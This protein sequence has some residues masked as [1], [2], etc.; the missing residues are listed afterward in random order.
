MK[1]LFT[2]LLNLLYP[3]LCIICNEILVRGES[4]ICLKCLH[5]M[6]K[7]NYHL[8]TDNTVEKRFWGKVQVHRATSCFHFYKGS[9][10]QKLL[11]ELKYHGNKEVGRV[12][13]KYAAIDLLDSPDF[14]SVDVIVPVPLHPKKYAKRGYNQSEWIAKG[15]SEVLNKP[16]DNSHLIRIRENATQTKKSIF[17]RY[18]NT[19]GIFTLNDETVFRKKHVLLVDDVLTTGSTLEACMMALMETDYITISVF[20]LAIA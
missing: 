17:E 9:P 5:E 18:Q 20:T 12:I 15:L 13:G 7:T 3:N 19:S 1:S 11:H 4:I 6:P 8:Q 2:N 14:C 16:V 10:F